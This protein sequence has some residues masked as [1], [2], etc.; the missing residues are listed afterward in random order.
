MSSLDILEQKILQAIKIIEQLSAENENLKKEIDIYLKKLQEREEPAPQVT[1]EP[2]LP[3]DQSQEIE[4]YK[5][6][7]AQIRLKIQGVI[8]KINQF[9]KL[10]NEV[11]TK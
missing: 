6:K 3:K 11:D 5:R 7:E 9:E 1:S 2:S 4:K 8:E 10:N